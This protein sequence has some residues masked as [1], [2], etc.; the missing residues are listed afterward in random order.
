M[1]QCNVQSILYTKQIKFK[2]HM[3]VLSICSLQC[4]HRHIVGVLGVLFIPGSAF[5]FQH[6]PQPWKVRLHNSTGSPHAL[7]AFTAIETDHSIGVVLSRGSLLP[8]LPPV[9]KP[10]HPSSPLSFFPLVSCGFFFFFFV[11]FFFFGQMLELGH[12][13]IIKLLCLCHSPSVL[14]VHWLNQPSSHPGRPLYTSF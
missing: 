1:L 4:S 6:G 10:S 2:P 12:R 3:L 8:L 7:R 5:P 9:T 13:L 11:V 14:F